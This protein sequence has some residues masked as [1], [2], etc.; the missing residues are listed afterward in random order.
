[1][2]AGPRRVR[3][4]RFRRGRQLRV[5]H[6]GARTPG[7][8]RGPRRGLPLHGHPL[9]RGPDGRR[10]TPTSGVAAAR[11][12]LV[13]MSGNAGGL[14]MAGR[15]LRW[16]T[17]AEAPDNRARSFVLLFTLERF[18]RLKPGGGGAIPV[19]STGSNAEC[20]RHASSARV[21]NLNDH[22][23][24]PAAACQ[25]WLRVDFSVSLYGH[26][27]TWKT[28][29]TDAQASPVGRLFRTRQLAVRFE[30]LSSGLLHSQ[31]AVGVVPRAARRP[32]GKA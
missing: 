13:P 12:W 16:S 6:G 2:R 19:A 4:R 17:R 28:M 25:P 9:I 20:Y 3:R 31:P 15:R 1:M 26:S 22:H 24:P 23:V 29:K 14:E 21:R 5:D 27:V 7:V 11:R 18:T 8:D 10:R 32:A 30:H